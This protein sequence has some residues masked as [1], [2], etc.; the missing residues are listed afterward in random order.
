MTDQVFGLQLAHQQLSL[1]H[2]LPPHGRTET[3]ARCAWE[4]HNAKEQ[5]HIASTMGVWLDGHRQSP[6]LVFCGFCGAIRYKGAID[7][8]QAKNSCESSRAERGG[9]QS[10]DS[11]RPKP[12]RYVVTLFAQQSE[13]RQSFTTG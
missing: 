13:G 3:P 6:W 11:G 1:K 10:L 2:A 12:P 7:N 9:T 5:Y 4:I 8:P